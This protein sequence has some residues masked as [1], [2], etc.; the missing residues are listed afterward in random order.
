MT[1]AAQLPGNLKRQP[2]AVALA[3]LRRRDGIVEVTPGKVEIG[4]GILTALAQ[5]VADELDV[6]LERVRMVAGQRPRRAPTRA[7]PRA[8]CRSR[9]P[10]RR[11]AMPC[12]EARAIYL[13][14]AAQR[15]GVAAENLEVEDGTI[16]GPGNLRTSY[17]ELADDALLARDATPGRRAPRRPRRGASPGTPAARLDMPDKVFGRPRFIHDLALPGMLHGRVLKPASPGARLDVAGRGGGARDAGVV[18]VVRDGSF[19]GVVAETEAA[20]EAG[21]RGSAQGA[22]WSAGDALPDETNLA[23]WLKSQPVETTT[24]DERKAAAPGASGPHGAPQYTRPFIAHA[25]MA[26]SCAVAQWTGAGQ[27]AR[28][29]AQPGHLQPARRPRARAG[30]AAGEH[31]R[32]AR[33]GRRLLRPERRR[34][35]GARRRAA[36]ARGRRA[37]GARAVV[38]RGRARLGAARRRHGRRHRGRPRRRRRDRRLA[39][40]RVEQRPRL[41]AGRAPTP[42]LLAASQLAKPFERFIATN[43]PLATGGG[44]ERNAVPL[45]DFPGHGASPAT[46]C[47]TCRSA[48]RRCARSAPSPTCSPSSPSWTSW[49]PSAA[50]TRWP[51]ACAT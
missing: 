35:R 4:Q 27:G 36:G 5:I 3:A 45:Y 19:V 50:R 23:A 44:A 26:P 40:R 39:P 42:T 17:W 29:V 21:A 25:S 2:A 34:R 48:P 33:R 31:R 12:A 46:G 18:A 7:S 1:A 13:G 43:P 51:S 37:S 14:A 38:A 15:L 30:A 49:R 9:I 41:A 11:C 16:V 22:A 24:V 47:S 6:G 8:A 10:A 28:L 20:A 32:R